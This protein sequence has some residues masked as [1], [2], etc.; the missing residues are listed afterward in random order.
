MDDLTLTFVR[1]SLAQQWAQERFDKLLSST[2]ELLISGADDHTLVLWSVFGRSG[3]GKG[4]KP[5]ARLTGHQRQVSHVAFSPDGRWIASGAWDN[6]V[7]LWDGK[8][9]KWELFIVNLCILMNSLH[10]LVGS[11]RLLG[12]TL[13]P[14]TVW[15]GLPTRDS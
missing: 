5:V 11:L 10:P 15:H 13:E 9:G 3:E 6:S 4:T 12:D 14:S 7:R 8:T 2:P 1:F